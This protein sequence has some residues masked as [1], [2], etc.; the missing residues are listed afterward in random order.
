MMSKSR[1]R[2]RTLSRVAAAALFAALPA[3]VARAGDVLLTI[4][5]SD[6][7]LIKET[8][9][10]DL[11]QG[12]GEVRFSDVT[13]LLEPDSVVLRDRRSPG[14]LRILEQNYEADPLSEAAMLRRS[15]GTTLRFRSVNPA[16]GAVEIA[17]AKLIRAG[18]GGS[19]PA[20][21]M[22]RGMQPFGVEAAP[23]SPI[24]EIDGRVLFGLPGQPLFDDLGDDAILHPTLLWKLWAERGGKR[25]VE[26]SYLTGGLRWEATYN[27]VAPEKGD[28]FDLVGWVTMENGSGAE[29][30]DAKVKLMAGEVS[31]VRQD[32]AG[33]AMMKTMAMESGM[34]PGPAVT[35][36]AFDEYH[37]YTLTEPTTLREREI[38]QV[39]FC[40]ADAVPGRRLYV[41]DG[42]QMA[43]YGGWDAEAMRVNPSY[44]AQGNTDIFTMVEFKNSKE[45]GLG[46]ALP[47]GTM[48]LYRADSDGSREFIGENTIDH[49]PADET[50]RLY[51][52][53]AFDLKAERRQ[54]DFKV[55][56]SRETATEAFEIRVRNHKKE[57]VEVRIVEHLY[58]WT[59]W[60]IAVSSDPYDKKDARTV[61]FRV[62]VPP[63]G[64]KLVTYRVNYSW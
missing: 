25:D 48:K 30:K 55:D 38:K 62:K 37:L 13:S 64:E 40:R 47:R 15:E 31:K 22:A 56:S 3:G 46:I 33:R 49:T 19:A 32:A 7:A 61:E 11:K 6:F 1:A 24:V 4:Y 23:L 35:E 8:R 26:V 54:T 20:W 44:G 12:I 59:G 58:R 60:K 43:A 21:R 9:T 14:G 27:L 17:T 18:Y 57:A 41:Y 52:G 28:N 29:F 2:I 50:V 34:A 16:T 10:L 36:K 53:N 42:A 39:E 5:N 63:D 51:L 45:S